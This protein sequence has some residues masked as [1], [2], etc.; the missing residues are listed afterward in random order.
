MKAVGA[1][2]LY[3]K[4]DPDMKQAFYT[5]YSN[6][7]KISTKK[8]LACL[9]GCEAR[10]A[11]DEIIRLAHYEGVPSRQVVVFHEPSA[12]TAWLKRLPLGAGV[13]P[14]V[15]RTCARLLEGQCSSEDVMI[16]ELTFLQALSTTA[17]QLSRLVNKY[18]VNVPAIVA[19]ARKVCQDDEME[20]NKYQVN[21]PAIVARA[22]KVCQDD[23]M[24][25]EVENC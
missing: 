10:K 12:D 22:R 17:V 3:P 19:R 2:T 20:Q 23:E 4:L 15:N 14:C 24:E 5:C 25:Q 21:V 11:A 7:G 1:V 6:F 13:S 18:Q 16:D 8:L 9:V